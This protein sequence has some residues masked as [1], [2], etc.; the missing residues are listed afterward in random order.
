MD[1]MSSVR[2]SGLEKTLAVRSCTPSTTPRGSWIVL[3]SVVGVSELDVEESSE[4]L[5]VLEA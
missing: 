3:V 2:L 1:L 5:E 4:I